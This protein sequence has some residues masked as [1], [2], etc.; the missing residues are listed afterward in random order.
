[1]DKSIQ[2]GS[3][4]IQKHSI[5]IRNKEYCKWIDDSYF[6][7]AK[8]Y[9]FKGEYPEAK[10]TFDFIK[11]KY[12]KT[13][14]AFESQLWTAKCYLALEDYH[15]AESIL[16]DME[17][18]YNLPKSGFDQYIRVLLAYGELSCKSLHNETIIHFIKK[19][20]NKIWLQKII[21]KKKVYGQIKD[22]ELN[23]L[24]KLVSGALILLFNNKINKKEDIDIWLKLAENCDLKDNNIFKSYLLFYVKN[25]NQKN[26]VVKNK[27]LDYMKYN[28]KSGVS[29]EFL[30]FIAKSSW[31]SEE[32]K[33][34]MF[35]SYI[36][37]LS[38][39]P[40]SLSLCLMGDICLSNNLEGKAKD[41]YDK[42]LNQ[43]TSIDIFI[44]LANFYLF[45]K[46]EKESIKYYQKAFDM[47]SS[48]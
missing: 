45:K 4:V 48:K 38:A 47:L 35:E 17:I 21:S 34:I 20:D 25:K 13:E 27:L 39:K 33:L 19:I 26:D 14:I 2:K 37:K 29:D 9:Y 28:S 23:K 31:L 3:V 18:N 36:S 41:N 1:M 8:A 43:K 46:D 5:N 24:I 32:D 11:K 12:K 30:V 6:L 44:S 42:S 10:K 7:V 16:D 40:S 15:S 22:K